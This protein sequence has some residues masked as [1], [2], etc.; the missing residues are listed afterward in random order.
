MTIRAATLAGRL[1]VVEQQQV[2]ADAVSA[3]R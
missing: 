3:K 2:A 1:T